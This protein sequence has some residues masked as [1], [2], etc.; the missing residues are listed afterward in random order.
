MAD[1]QLEL[2]VSFQSWSELEATD[3]T[4]IS[5]R[6]S[7]LRRDQP[8]LRDWEDTVSVRLAA[9]WAVSPSWMLSGG[10]ALEPSPVPTETLDPAFPISDALVYSAGFSYQRPRFAV[11]IGFSF[12]DFDDRATRRLLAPTGDTVSAG[13]VSGEQRLTGVSIRWQV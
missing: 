7:S 10:L 1:L 9:E 13:S 4:L 6:R 11:D 5:G 3:I 2:D 8:Q 12:H